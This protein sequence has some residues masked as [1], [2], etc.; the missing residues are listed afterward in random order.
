MKSHL[1]TLFLCLDSPIQVIIR[2][3]SIL[4]HVHDIADVIQ[5][6]HNIISGG[7]AGKHSY[8]L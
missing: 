3:M 2:D 6:V 4:L 5:I 1:S 8:I 7:V